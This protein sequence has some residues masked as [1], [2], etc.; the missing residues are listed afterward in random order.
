MVLIENTARAMGKAPEFVKI[1]HIVNRG[2]TIIGSS[3]PR[4]RWGG[5]KRAKKDG[6]ASLRHPANPSKFCIAKGAASAA[7]FWFKGFIF[8]NQA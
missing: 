6:G 5:E 3:L 1:R 7:P 4:P 8:P 2:F